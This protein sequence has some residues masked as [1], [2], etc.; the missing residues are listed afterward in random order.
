M[1]V[2]HSDAAIE[3]VTNDVGLGHCHFLLV[4]NSCEPPARLVL[5]THCVD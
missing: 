4:F 2:Q 5:H 1:S 3:L